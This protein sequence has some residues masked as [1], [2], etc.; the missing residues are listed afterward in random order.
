MLFVS[1]LM[2]LERITLEETPD[3]YESGIFFSVGKGRIW[4]GFGNKLKVRF[5]FGKD[6]VEEYNLKRDEGDLKDR[7]PFLA[8]ADNFLKEQDL[9]LVKVIYHGNKIKFPSLSG[10]LYRRKS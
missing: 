5:D 10:E 2:V 4:R 6:G 1:R 7:D 9:Y 8:V 3:N